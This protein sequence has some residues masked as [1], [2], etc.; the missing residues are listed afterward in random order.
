[1]GNKDFMVFTRYVANQ[2][3]QEGYN[4]LR[5]KPDKNDK[6]HTIYVFKWDDTIEE[7]VAKI[8]KK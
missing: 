3:I 8:N 2:L 4:I 7:A 5:L 1:M 6:A